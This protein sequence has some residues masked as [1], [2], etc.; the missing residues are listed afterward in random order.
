MMEPNMRLEQMRRWLA[1]TQME[2][3]YT[4]FLGTTEPGCLLMSMVAHLDYPLDFA[5]KQGS[6]RS[7]DSLFIMT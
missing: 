6:R 5:Q 4:A 7:L 3:N 2:E 1:Q